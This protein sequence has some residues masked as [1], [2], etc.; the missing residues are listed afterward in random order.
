MT[1]PDC[2]ADHPFYPTKG[3]A[4]KR[5]IPF[6]LTRKQW[7]WLWEREFGPN[8]L[9]YRGVRHG[10]YCMARFGDRG[11]YEIGNVRIILTTDN[12]REGRTRQYDFSQMNGF[13]SLPA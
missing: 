3:N 10:Q 2:L 12:T 8:W 1:Y 4:R 13:L 9:H 6:H 7:E 11:A 5:G